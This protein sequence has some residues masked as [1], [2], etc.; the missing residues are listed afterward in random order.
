MNKKLFKAPKQRTKTKNCKLKGSL[1][2]TT[3]FHIRKYQAEYF[4]QKYLSK[5]CQ[6]IG[7]KKET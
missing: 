1:F 6:F 5:T 7:I 3:F 4:K 2:I